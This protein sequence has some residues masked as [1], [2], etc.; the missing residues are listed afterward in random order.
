MIVI[1]AVEFAT[2]SAS[3]QNCKCSCYIQCY[4]I[5]WHFKLFLSQFLILNSQISVSNAV[6]KQ[7]EQQTLE[8]RAINVNNGCVHKLKVMN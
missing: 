2:I 1:V 8:T 7:P 6:W 4:I 3:R 5:L